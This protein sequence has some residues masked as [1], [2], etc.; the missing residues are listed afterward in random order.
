MKKVYYLLSW[1]LVIALILSLSILPIANAQIV[2]RYLGSG[3]IEK[4]GIKELVATD[5]LPTFRLPNVDH[6]AL[7]KEDSINSLRGIPKRF[8]KAFDVNVDVMAAGK[9][10]HSSDSITTVYAVS[11]PLLEGCCLR[12]G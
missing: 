4:Y 5:Q 6:S 12:L 9:Q 10:F 2:T 11:F 3:T 8:G 7:L 1:R